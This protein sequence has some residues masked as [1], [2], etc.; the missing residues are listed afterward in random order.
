MS[1]VSHRFDYYT[2]KFDQ[3]HLER[4]REFARENPLPDDLV[5]EIGA[6]RGRFL[7]GL[8]QR[9]PDR[10]IL[11]IEW[12]KKHV[13]FAQETLAELGLKNAAMLQADANHAIP[14]IIKDGQIG[15]LFILF[16]DPWWKARHRKRRVI[17][18][19]FLDLIAQKM[20]D[21]GRLF[22]RTD[23]GTFADDMQ[24]IIDAHPEF[25]PLSSDEIPLQPFPRTTR[26]VSIM[27]KG[28]PI[29][30]LYY[31]RRPRAQAQ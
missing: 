25:I 14:L 8:A 12:R 28:L 20:K 24:E 5:I 22:I 1:A 4:I 7:T 10:F 2:E 19:Q 15:D 26:E 27:R 16:P 9:W 23:V 3:W 11:G 17:Q 29:H 13:D 31:R 21:N 6:N 18:P 30:L